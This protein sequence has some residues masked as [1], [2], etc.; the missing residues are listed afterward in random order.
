MVMKDKLKDLN[1]DLKLEHEQWVWKIVA[2]MFVFGVGALT[3]CTFAA[4]IIILFFI[5]SD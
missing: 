1:E 5:W 2:T 3:D 4:W